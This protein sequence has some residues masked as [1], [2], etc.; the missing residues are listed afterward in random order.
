MRANG[1]HCVKAQEMPRRATRVVD[2]ARA[3]VRAVERRRVEVRRCEAVQARGR[4][5]LGSV[6]FEGCRGVDKVV[7]G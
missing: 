4:V 1:A 2:G 3:V 5:R 7:C 6:R